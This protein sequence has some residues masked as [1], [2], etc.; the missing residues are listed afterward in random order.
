[1]FPKLTPLQWL[2]FLLFL[3]FYGFAVFAVTRD[4]YVRNPPRPVAAS[5]HALPDDASA[6][7]GRM[8]E[9][10]SDT[11]SSLPEELLNANP[12]LI[13]QEADRLF[14]EQRFAQAITLYRRVLELDPADV[15]TRNDLG[16]ALHYAGNTR[17]ALEILR[18][19]SEMDP[20]FQR[21]WLSLGF[22]SVQADETEQ[23]RT[24]LTR[25]RELDPET[26][27]GKEAARLLDLL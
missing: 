13:S 6:L 25:A 14:A 10:L 19:G 1:M 2:L 11:D 15:G 23:A 21:I 27:I 9:A 20:D 16:L 18:E 12:T 3:F 22:V 8:R 7:G 4:Y 5:P 24:A 17:D 26:D